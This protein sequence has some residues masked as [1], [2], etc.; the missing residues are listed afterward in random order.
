MKDLKT[1]YTWAALSPGSSWVRRAAV[2]LSNVAFIFSGMLL[3][4][5]INGFV[6]SSS[7]KLDTSPMLSTKICK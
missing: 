6:I 5:I 3:Y 7:M 1:I 2:V 4:D